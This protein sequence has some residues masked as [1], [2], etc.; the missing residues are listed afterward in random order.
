MSR[1]KKRLKPKKAPARRKAKK[2]KNPKKRVKKSRRSQAKFPALEKKYNLLSRQELI[3]DFDYIHLL[4]DKE[5]AFLNKFVEEEINASFKHS[6]PLNKTKS[7]RRECYN[8]NNRRNRCLLTKNKILG[9]MEDLS[10]VKEV[11]QLNP[12]EILIGIQEKELEEL[13]DFDNSFD[14]SEK[15]KNPAE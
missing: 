12:E 15:S 3:G 4:N 10:T 6:K 2:S 13:N 1:K 5:K 7:E 9:N 8:S 11:S 14:G